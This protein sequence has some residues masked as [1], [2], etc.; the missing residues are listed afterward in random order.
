M[1]N[2][3]KITIVVFL[4]VLAGVIVIASDI[5]VKQGDLSINRL[6][7]AGSVGIGVS[8]PSAQFQVNRNTVGWAGWIE[9]SHTGGADSGLLVKAGD[10]SSDTSLIVN[11]RTGAKVYLK[12]RGDGNV[13]IGTSNPG[14]KLDVAGTVKVSSIAGKVGY[15]VCV[16][17]GGVLGTCSTAISATGTCTC[18]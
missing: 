16:K 10:D 4:L 5:I 18:N 12:V 7:T 17:S 11:D 15:G 13:G 9:N 1:K 3:F 14:A 8:A 2:I 6:T